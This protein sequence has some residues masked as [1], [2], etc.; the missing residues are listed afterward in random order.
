MLNKIY[1]QFIILLTVV[2]LSPYCYAAEDVDS[3]VAIVEEDVVL[4]SE[5]DARVRTI[6]NQLMEQ[7][8]SLPPESVMEKQV[9]DRLILSKLQIQMA[10]NTGIRVDDET[11][12]RTISSIAAE[13]E[14]TLDQFR[15]ILE[16]DGYTYEN[17]REDIRN[18]IL[19]SRLRQR[20]VDNRVFVSDRE[21]DDFLINLQHQGGMEKEYLISHVLISL[22]ESPTQ[23]DLEQSRRLANKVQT[24]LRE[25]ADIAAIAATYSDG[26]QALNGGDLGWLKY[27]QVPTLFVEF[28]ATMEKSDISELIRSPSGYHI[29][30]IMDIRD[31]E[32]LVVTQTLARHIFIKPSE[33]NSEEDV[34]TRLLSLKRRIENG[35]DFSELARGN[36]EDVV[37]AADGGDLGW[38][39]PGDL[40]PEFENVMDEVAINSVSDP[41]QEQQ[42]WHIVQVLDRR[43]H[44]GTDDIRRARA[45][46]IIR[47]RK[48]DEES[49]L[50]LTQL[51]DDAYVEYRLE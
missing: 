23:E 21:I 17:F 9:L 42:G 31:A 14:L 16:A 50:W 44:D 5:L 22:P 46:E 43:E 7:G 15:E 37:T 47:Q 2:T 49:E 32:K 27:S 12:N 6:T 39:S 34:K 28:I 25:D 29:I 26:D 19:L 4:R 48:M 35:D 51:R 11:L 1:R 30:K 10:E 13:N 3:I 24:E 18:E 8:T 45:R 40:T 36:S 33:L 38:V 20:Q 41:I